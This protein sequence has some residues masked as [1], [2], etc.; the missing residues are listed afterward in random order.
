VLASAECVDKYCLW[1]FVKAHVPA[2]VL[3][4]MQDQL[5]AS[6]PDADLKSIPKV[7]GE[8]DLASDDGARPVCLER[9]DLICYCYCLLVTL[10][11]DIVG[12]RPLRI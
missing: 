2:D 5:A 11:T 7:D 3:W 10:E 4:T 8:R 12:S 9:F 1:P 6:P